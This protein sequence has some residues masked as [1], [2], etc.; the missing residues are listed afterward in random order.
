[1]VCRAI[2]RKWDDS[3]RYPVD[4]KTTMGKSFGNS[5]GKRHCVAVQH[6]YQVA[7]SRTLSPGS[8]DEYA[9]DH[10]SDIWSHPCVM[11]VF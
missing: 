3:S 4:T 7:C 5:S 2:T 10:S 6:G 11:V 1:M 8:S 9:Y